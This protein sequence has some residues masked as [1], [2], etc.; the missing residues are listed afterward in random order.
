MSVGTVGR[1]I[2]TVTTISDALQPLDHPHAQKE[3]RYSLAGYLRSRSRLALLDF[4]LRAISEVHDHV[5]ADGLV[6]GAFAHSLVYPG[7]ETNPKNAT[8]FT[9]GG[10]ERSTVVI[11]TGIWRTRT[12]PL[13]RQQASARSG[14]PSQGQNTQAKQTPHTTF[15]RSYGTAANAVMGAKLYTRADH[16]RCSTLWY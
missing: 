2:R 7:V 11:P 4:Y 1:S 3:F 6:W 15:L 9:S 12:I 5:V 16:S 14:C 8:Q 13:N 10:S